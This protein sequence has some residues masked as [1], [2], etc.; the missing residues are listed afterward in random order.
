[1]KHLSYILTFLL[2]GSIGLSLQ[3]MQVPAEEL[4]NNVL[5]RVAQ[6]PESE[7]IGV[8][9]S[10]AERIKKDA[11]LPLQAYHQ[12]RHE[13]QKRAPA[14]I[15]SSAY[16]PSSPTVT[17]PMTLALLAEREQAAASLNGRSHVTGVPYG[18]EFFEDIL[19]PPASP[20]PVI[21]VPLPEEILR[22]IREDDRSLD[23]ASAIS[24]APNFGALP[25]DHSAVN[26]RAATL[27][28]VPYQPVPL[29]PLPDVQPAPILSKNIFQTL[30]DLW[31]KRT[32]S[33]RTLFVAS[34]V[35]FAAV[36]TAVSS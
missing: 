15:S 35:L 7:Q 6:L 18:P 5:E 27:A 14:S 19:P 31:R 20:F 29:P 11:S 13:A 2:M 30:C 9:L 3:A 34:S 25:A 4:V 23:P 10:E 24:A 32:A 12:L 26:E 36:F 17:R 22:A 33:Q 16:S 8:L 1:M 28:S 21:G